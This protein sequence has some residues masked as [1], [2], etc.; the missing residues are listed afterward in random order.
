MQS[1]GE[2][3]FEDQSVARKHGLTRLCGLF[4]HT[5][6]FHNYISPP[7]PP[8]P[9]PHPRRLAGGASWI[10]L[11]NRFSYHSSLCCPLFFNW[12]HCLSAQHGM[13]SRLTKR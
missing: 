8:P 4:H 5:A 3:L 1:I 6:T 9:P 11:C 7:P 13:N 10:S 2:Q 12:I